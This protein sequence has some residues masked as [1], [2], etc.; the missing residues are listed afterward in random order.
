[1]LARGGQLPLY[2]AAY[3]VNSVTGGTFNK[4]LRRTWERELL[5][6][7]LSQEEIVVKPDRWLNE[8]ELYLIRNFVRESPGGQRI[9]IRLGFATVEIGYVQWDDSVERKFKSIGNFT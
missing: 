4:A 6:A 8:N 9:S 1:K 2:S 3:S 5:G 7:S